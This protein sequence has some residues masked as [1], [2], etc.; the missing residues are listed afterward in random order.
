MILVSVNYD[1][2][3]N[4]NILR[5]Y[6]GDDGEKTMPQVSDRFFIIFSPLAR[7]FI[8]HMTS[9]KYEGKK[10]IEADAFLVGI[11]RSKSSSLHASN[12]H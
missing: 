5:A 9:V 6:A 3:M 2:S 7:E 10:E 8:Y 11:Y 4:K 12:Q 1:F